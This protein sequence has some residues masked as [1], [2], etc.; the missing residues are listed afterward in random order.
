[1]AKNAHFGKA[2]LD[3]DWALKFLNTLGSSAALLPLSTS[4][5]P[6]LFLFLSK[7]E[8]MSNAPFSSRILWL[9]TSPVSLV[10][11]VSEASL[12][13]LGTQPCGSLFL[14]LPGLVLSSSY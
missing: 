10:L 1:M 6:S 12:D 2:T 7:N 11:G 5:F 4:I 9:G 13:L 14:H 8:M 3:G